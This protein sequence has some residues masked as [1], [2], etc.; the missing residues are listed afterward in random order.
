M[1]KKL[2]YN[3][4]ENIICSR[5]PI[6]RSFI[7]YHVLIAEK[8]NA[9]NGKNNLNKKN[10]VVTN[11]INRDNKSCSNKLEKK[12]SK[13]EIV[14]IGLVIIIGNHHLRPPHPPVPIVVVALVETL[15]IMPI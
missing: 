10:F 15:V 3:V 7:L 13:R 2:P 1:T 6:Q 9:K 14:L 4:R 12:W 11:S 8:K 5:F